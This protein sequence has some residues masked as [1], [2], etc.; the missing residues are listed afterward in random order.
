[1]TSNAISKPSFTAEQIE[2]AIAAAPEKLPDDPDFPPLSD[3]F[4]ENAIVS[5]SY[6]ELKEKLAAR[7]KGRGPGKAPKKT[8]TTIR[9]DPDVLAGL[10][11]LGS[12]W[13]SRVNETLRDWLAQHPVSGVQ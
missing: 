1:M 4:F 12:G 13:Q 7:R 8:S 10:R 9:L 5:H 3:E 11:A 2:A 6:A